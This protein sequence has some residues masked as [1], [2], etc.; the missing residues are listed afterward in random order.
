MNTPKN[1]FPEKDFLVSQEEKSKKLKQQPK[2]IWLTGL[3]GSGKS[4]VAKH[5]EKLLFDKGFSTCIL[6]GDNIR[7][8]LNNNLSFSEE[9]R[10]ENIRRIAEVAKLFTDNGLIC[11]CAFVSPTKEIRQLAKNIITPERYIEVFINTPIDVCEERDVKG[12]Y[13]KARKGEVK[14]FTGIS[15]PFD[16]PEFGTISITTSKT[17]MESAQELF[18]VLLPKLIL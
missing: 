8:G 6:D 12:L 9:D 13:A 18:E 16:T 15:A 17:P 4:T 5:L 14:D 11:I 10:L 7:S 2:V 3:S 1:I